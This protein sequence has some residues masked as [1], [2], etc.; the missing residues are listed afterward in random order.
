MGT[1]FMIQKKDSCGERTNSG[2][3]RG[4]AVAL[5]KKSH[6]PP[7]RRGQNQ[8]AAMRTEA[9]VPLPPRQRERLPSGNF[10]Q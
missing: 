7:K 9:P 8:E 10:Q 3:R 2:Q 4:R 6:K 1:Q 5:N